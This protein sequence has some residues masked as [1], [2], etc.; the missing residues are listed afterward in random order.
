MGD[1]N[2]SDGKR[3]RRH[4]VCNV[5]PGLIRKW[6][7]QGAGWWPASLRPHSLHKILF[8]SIISEHTQSPFTMQ[9]CNGTD[10]RIFFTKEKIIILSFTKDKNKPVERTRWWR[11][12]WTWI[13][14]SLHGYIRNI[15]SD[16]EVHTEYQ[17]RVDR[18]T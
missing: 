13:H 8:S 16:T 14:V 5:E 17:L 4:R 18:S 3:Q 9:E 2:H 7:S 11:S 12:R 6:Q 15:P 10:W 1:E